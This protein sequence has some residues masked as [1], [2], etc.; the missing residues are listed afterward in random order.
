MKQFPK[1]KNLNK[2]DI[3]AFYNQIEKALSL[4]EVDAPLPEDE[5]RNF[6]DAFAIMEGS[7]NAL[8]M[9]EKRIILASEYGFIGLDDY[10]EVIDNDSNSVDFM[11]LDSKYIT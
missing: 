6:C 2:T 7:K 8:S 9:K 3:E 10:M 1:L 5:R 4:A 11:V